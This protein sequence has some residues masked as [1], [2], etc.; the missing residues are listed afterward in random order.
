MPLSVL[1]PTSYSGIPARGLFCS[2]VEG[3]APLFVQESFL[4]REHVGLLSRE[5]ARWCIAWGR[6]AVVFR[7]DGA[8]GLSL[9]L[10]LS[11]SFCFLE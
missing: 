9:S 11:L 8:D 3:R 10:S 7:V 4:R 5:V 6:F 2:G 1:L